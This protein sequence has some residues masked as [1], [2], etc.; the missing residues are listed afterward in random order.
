MVARGAV[1]ALGDYYVSQEVVEE[2]VEAPVEEPQ[3]Q[4]ARVIATE[5]QVR[6]FASDR[7]PLYGDRLV[8]GQIVVVGDQE[9]EY[10]VVRLPLGAT[11]YVHKKFA[12]DAGD[13][14][15]E[16]TAAR[17]SFRY[18]PKSSEVPALVMSKGATL[19]YLGEEGD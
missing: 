18:R 14:K 8:E 1:D 6:C 19:F 17:V 4:Y 3:L 7:S 12:T 2:P 15:V 16:A 13:G 10:R 9:G 11:G 5:T